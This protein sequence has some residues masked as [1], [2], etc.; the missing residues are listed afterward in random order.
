[1]NGQWEDALTKILGCIEMLIKSSNELAVILYGAEVWTVKNV[2]KKRLEVFEMLIYKLVL[3]IPW[4][5]RVPN[6]QPGV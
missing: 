1:M 2:D 3:K 4:T 6:H 5:Y